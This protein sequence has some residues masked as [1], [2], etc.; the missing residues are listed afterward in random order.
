[1]WLHETIA[2]LN[3]CQQVLALAEAPGRYIRQ[4]IE[5]TQAELLADRDVSTGGRKA[6]AR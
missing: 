5:G 3:K 2:Q 6:Q 4:R 1:M